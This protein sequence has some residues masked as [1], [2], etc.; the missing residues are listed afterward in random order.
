MTTLT[1]PLPTAAIQRFC[2]RWK[3]RE[4]A[5]FVSGA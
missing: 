2:R 1:L 3:I 4:P 5:L